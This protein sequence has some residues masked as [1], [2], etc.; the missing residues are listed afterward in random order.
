[1]LEIFQW[2]N[3]DKTKKLD[4]IL[5]KKISEEVA[6]I[7]LYLIRFSD[8]AKI[9]I[10]KECFKKIKKNEKKYPIKLSK[11]ISKKYNEL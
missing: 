9:D 2:F 8:V 11:G 5:K 3:E 7:M 10:E 6:D 1:M 4:K